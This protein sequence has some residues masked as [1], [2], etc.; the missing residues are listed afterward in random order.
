[1]K[2]EKELDKLLLSIQKELT[3]R[4]YHKSEITKN[5]E[6]IENHYLRTKMRY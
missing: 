2:N 1:M 3:F 4:V 6:R 5:R